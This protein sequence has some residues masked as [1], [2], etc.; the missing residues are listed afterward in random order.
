MRKPRN[1]AVSLGSLRREWAEYIRN[2]IMEKTSV[3]DVLETNSIMAAFLM[4]SP[5]YEGGTVDNSMVRTNLTQPYTI[6]SYAGRGLQVDRNVHVLDTDIYAY[7]GG[8]VNKRILVFELPTGKA[9][10][11]L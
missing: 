10:E 6:G 8:D 3:G 4:D 9:Y 2:S 7:V 5:E 1:K 11:L